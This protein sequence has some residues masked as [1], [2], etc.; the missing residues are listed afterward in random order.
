MAFDFCVH[1]QYSVVYVCV[2]AQWCVCVCLY[3]CVRVRVCVCVYMYNMLCGMMYMYSV[4]T[5]ITA[6]LMTSVMLHSV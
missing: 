6:T 1:V 4:Y 2:H 3:V 5:C